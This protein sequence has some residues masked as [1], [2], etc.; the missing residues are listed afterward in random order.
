MSRDVSPVDHAQRWARYLPERPAIGGAGERWSYGELDRRAQRTAVF[1]IDEFGLARGDRVALLADNH[2]FFFELAFACFRAGL[3]LAPLNVRL[4]AG[5]LEVLLALAAP[6]VLF[7][8]AAHAELAADLRSPPGCRTVDIGSYLADPP[9]AVAPRAP[10]S[11]SDFEEPALLLFTSGTTGRAKAAVLPVRQLF[12][13]AV[14]TQLAFGLT[15]D[16]ATV[17]YTPLFHTGAVNVLALPLLQVG[18]AVH[19]MERFAPDEVARIVAGERISTFFGVPTTLQTL[20][21]TPGFFTAAARS[22]RLCLCG[23]APLA[24]NLI[25]TYERHGVAL[26]QGFG[27]TEAG[28]NCF[29]LPPAALREHAGAVGKPIHY[30]D[31]RLVCDGREARLDEVGELWLRGPHVC[32][33]YFRDSAATAAA[34]EDGWFRTGDLLKRDEDGFYTVAGRLKEMFISG[35]ENVY[36]AEI[37]V[38]LHG[39]PAVA[40]CAVV[41]TPDARWGEVGCAF[42]VVQEPVSGEALRGFLRERLAH[43]KI[44]KRF[45]FLENLPLNESGKVLKAHLAGEARRHAAA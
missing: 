12:W 25:R 10:L 31:A 8:D 6:R 34:F 15:G 5:E 13:N 20:A 45:V 18:G 2:P 1:L 30:G 16:D 37:E 26:T 21:A 35:G 43:Y 38:A 36:P 19:V 9:A 27:M 24:V 32:S 3:V 33:G 14:N 11:G 44:P 23:G 17:V 29:F 39:H 28:P 42:A 22:V 7:A 40:K 41:A 4:A